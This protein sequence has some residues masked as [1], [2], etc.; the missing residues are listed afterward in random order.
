M[1]EFVSTAKYRK[2][3]HSISYIYILMFWYM[4]Y[5]IVDLHPYPNWSQGNNRT[6][7]SLLFVPATKA[8]LHFVLGILRGRQCD[9]AARNSQVVVRM[10]SSMCEEAFNQICKH[11]NMYDFSTYSLQI[12]VSN[13]NAMCLD[14]ALMHWSVYWWAF[15]EVQLSN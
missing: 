15:W 13:V 4:S 5:W 3:V 14:E 6:P 9:M 8:G 7:A 12:L 2:K 11:K 1:A 10:F